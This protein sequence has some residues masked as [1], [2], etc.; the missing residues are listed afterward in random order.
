MVGSSGDRNCS[1]PIQGCGSMLLHAVQIAQV[2]ANLQWGST[3]LYLSLLP[4]KFLRLLFASMSPWLTFFL[5]HDVTRCQSQQLPLS[6]W[7]WSLAHRQA[8]GP[9]TGLTATNDY[10]LELAAPGPVIISSSNQMIQA[11]LLGL[12]ISLPVCFPQTPVLWHSDM[13]TFLNSSQAPKHQNDSRH[14]TAPGLPDAWLG[15][16]SHSCCHKDEGQLAQGH[17][18]SQP[19]WWPSPRFDF[20]TELKFPPKV[21]KQSAR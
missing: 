11:H 6:N 12:C 5:C 10:K 21:P 4:F 15:P 13:I 9:V 18:V 8:S 2:L 20:S 17:H 1:W 19:Q 7:L 14:V 3:L 16:L